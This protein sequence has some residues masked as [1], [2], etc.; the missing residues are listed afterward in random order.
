MFGWTLHLS[1]TDTN[2]ISKWK[3]VERSDMPH[4]PRHLGDPSGMS[5]TISRPMA[6]SMETVQLYCVKI[7][8][9]S[10]RTETSFHLSLVI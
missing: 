4:D 6:R 3:E 2:T 8:T 7:S 9:I 10:E 1:C 5:K